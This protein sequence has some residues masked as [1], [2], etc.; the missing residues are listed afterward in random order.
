[1]LDPDVLAMGTFIEHAWA[2]VLLSSGGV[3]TASCRVLQAAALRALPRAACAL[4]LLQC[5]VSALLCRAAGAQG[6]VAAEPL[7]W[8]RCR[9]SLP[10]A[11]LRLLLGWSQLAALSRGSVEAFIAAHALAT[12][13]LSLGSSVLLSPVPALP[14]LQGR[15][16]SLLAAA[17][18]CTLLVLLCQAP[19]YGFLLPLLALLTSLLLLAALRAW[20]TLRA[21]Q[22][23]AQDSPDLPT[24]DAAPQR[25]AATARAAQAAVH[26]L[27]AAL[28]PSQGADPPPPAVPSP[29]ELLFYSSA[30]PLPLLA[31]LSLARGELLHSDVSVPTLT[32]LLF[33]ALAQGVAAVAML[34]LAET[35]A[36]RGAQMRRAGAGC[37]CAGLLLS[38][39]GG[40]GVG[41]AGGAA[42][43]GAVVASAAF[44]SSLEAE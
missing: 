16:R 26:R 39:L 5:S 25:L 30:L 4:L 28:C 20:E 21:A 29:F 1:V 23:L 15:Q 36:L 13:L 34:L 31:A 10:E 41:V 11:A 22:P 12:P 44:Q 2:G 14:S 3:A 17:A 7:S 42:A 38:A 27:C 19:L 18:A 33:A 6:V 35:Q 8:S 37:G 40:A 9:L 32:V 24:P 43:A